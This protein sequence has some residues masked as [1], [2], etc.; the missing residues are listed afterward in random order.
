MKRI[1]RWPVSGTSLRAPSTALRRSATPALTALI[2]TKLEAVRLA[3]TLASVVLPEPG[4]PQKIIEPTWSCSIDRRRILPGPR[5]CSWPTN[6]SKVRGRIR[7]AS[8]SL[9]RNATS[10]PSPS[11]S[12]R[13]ERSVAKR[14]S[15]LEPKTGDVFVDG[16]AR[17]KL[18]ER[19][20]DEHGHHDVADLAHDR[21]GLQNV[22]RRNHHAHGRKYG[23]FLPYGY[24]RV[25]EQ[26]PD[27]PGD[28]RQSQEGFSSPHR[29]HG[30]SKGQLVQALLDSQIGR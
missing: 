3:M 2:A 8:G 15:P 24:S 25:L 12:G 6:S 21:N 22:Q 23:G 11:K 20:Q 27:Q 7:A 17:R 5:M 29:P 14:D 19:V 1:V 18:D 4:G 16:V 26:R 10:F 13:V 9:G 30:R 28:A